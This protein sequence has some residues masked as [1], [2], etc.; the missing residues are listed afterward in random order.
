GEE[1]AAIWRGAS[2]YEGKLPDA[3]VEARLGAVDWRRDEV[4]LYVG[5][6]IAAKGAQAV[7]AAM[8]AVLRERPAARFV[9]VGHGPLREPLESLVWAL[10]RGDEALVRR[11]VG[12]ASLVEDDPHAEGL[13]GV[14]AWLDALEAR[15]ELEDYLAQAARSRLGERV[16][17]TGYLTH[18]H[19]RFL[20]P[21]ADVAVFPSLVREAGPLVFLEALAS[22]VFPL[23]TYFGGMAASI[24]EAGEVVPARVAERMKLRTPDAPEG[25]MVRDIVQGTVAALADAEDYG[26]PL[27]DMVSA[28]H[29]WR[30]VAA[31]LRDVLSRSTGARRD[32]NGGG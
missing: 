24:D 2:E 6:M 30:S 5:R 29:D 21:V 23:G 8:P 4:V 12:A 1:L 28:R 9:L 22:E 19:L 27:R 15:G 26:G 20:F 11:I 14:G 32:G 31:R 7:V 13:A 16:V 10:E 18:D 3:G 25:G 17:F